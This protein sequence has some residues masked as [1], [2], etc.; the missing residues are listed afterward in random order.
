MSILSE[1]IADRCVFFI[2]ATKNKK[3]KAGVSYPRNN[4]V[5][6]CLKSNKIYCKK[7]RFPTDEEIKKEIADCELYV[8]HMREK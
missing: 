5:F 4:R 8:D 7:Q 2:G 3:C 1:H 6:P